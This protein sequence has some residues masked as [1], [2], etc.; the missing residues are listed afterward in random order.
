M[1]QSKVNRKL[2]Y[3]GADLTNTSM[4]EGYVT[5]SKS[6]NNSPIHG[7][8][9]NNLLPLQI[10]TSDDGLETL[11]GAAATVSLL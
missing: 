1:V 10:I 7:A 2:A 9:E 5:Q 4:S 3:L 11:A 8:G 6:K